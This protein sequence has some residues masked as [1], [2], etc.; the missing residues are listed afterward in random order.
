M[1][2][3]LIIKPKSWNAGEKSDINSKHKACGFSFQV[4]RFDGEAKN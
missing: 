2:Y 4:V 3:M 1:S